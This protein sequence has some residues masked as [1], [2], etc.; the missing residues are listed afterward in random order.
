MST[1]DLSSN[2]SDGDGL[3]D[4]SRDEPWR[5]LGDVAIRRLRAGTSEGTVERDAALADA[6]VAFAATLGDPTTFAAIVDN[7]ALSVVEAQ[8]LAIAVSCELDPHLS[9]LVAEVHDDLNRHR[10]SLHM[11]DQLLVGTEATIGDVLGVDSAL[12]RCGFVEILEDGPWA[13]HTVVVH[14]GVIW[15]FVGD[16]AMDP[17]ISSTARIHVD[18]SNSPGDDDLVVVTGDDRVRRRHEAMR[19]GRA[20][21]FIVVAQPTEPGVWAALVRE[22]TLSGLG[23]VVELDD[24]L[25][26][27]AR[28]TITRTPHLAWAITSRRPMAITDMPNRPWLEF[29]AEST[30]PTDAEWHE[31]IGDQDRRRHHLT[32]EQLELVGRVF[33]ASHGDLDASVRRLVAGPLEQL[34]QRIQPTRTWDDIVLSP[35]RF[36]HLRGIV[37]RYRYASTVFDEWGFSAKPS[38]GLVALFSGSSG[39]GKTLVAEIIAGELGLDVFKLNLSA[40][41]SKYIGETEK[42]LEQIFDAAGSGNV[43]LFFDEAD[44][45]FGKRSE[46]KDARDRYANLEVSYLLQRLERYDGVVLL[47]TNFEKN[48]DEAFLRRIHARVEF[49]LPAAAERSKIW[50]RNFPKGAPLQGVD[51]DFLS[52]RFD[53]SGGTIR[54]AAIHAAFLAAAAGSPILMDHAVISIARELRKM[55]RLL[56]PDQF[57]QYF[58]LAKDAD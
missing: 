5:R 27:D 51:F 22:A 33:R 54:N 4:V 45:L 23:I 44:S 12:R 39:T 19:R 40:V 53:M 11:V 1:P 14:P 16:A 20:Q 28:R 49:P 3:A 57:G 42:N 9:R 52:E 31:N 55:G 35:D 25:T 58:A 2:A 46:V 24:A 15:A 26:A 43:V 48:I 6:R 34:A 21:R 8:V 7:A 10:L 56:K 17:L 13:H 41:V 32:S 18:E 30:E 38:R 36:Q 47:A 29:V 37:D 50:R